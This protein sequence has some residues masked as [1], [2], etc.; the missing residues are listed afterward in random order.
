VSRPE[1]AVRPLYVRL[2]RLRHLRLSAM[3]C[4]VLFEGMMAL[5]VLLALTELVDWWAPV[6]LPGTVALMVKI[7]DLVAG[8]AARP[9][10]AVR[11]RVASGGAQRIAVGRASVSAPP[12]GRPGPP[13]VPTSP[14]P[15]TDT[16]ATVRA[17]V[18]R[19][20]AT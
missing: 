10:E 3:R 7:N 18:H 15:A 19:R 12:A 1:G 4:F 9:E 11:V 8:A 6:A 20:V 5:G 14:A 16:A 13:A 17:Q 2:L